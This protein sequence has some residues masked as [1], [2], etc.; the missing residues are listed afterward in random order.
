MGSYTDRPQDNRFLLELK[1][2]ICLRREAFNFLQSLA[3]EQPLCC[4]YSALLLQ[5]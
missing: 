1:K 4:Q 5:S 2:T 3:V